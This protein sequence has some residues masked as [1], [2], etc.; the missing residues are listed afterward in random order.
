MNL[1]PGV[2]TTFGSNVPGRDSLVTIAYGRISYAWCWG[3][4]DHYYLRR[5]REQNAH[6]AELYIGTIPGGN[7][8]RLLP[9]ECPVHRETIKNQRE[10]CHLM[11]R[12]SYRPL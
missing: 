10:I 12:E 1:R 8:L 5:D 7:R 11:S 4:P 2:R 6:I 3:A 9:V